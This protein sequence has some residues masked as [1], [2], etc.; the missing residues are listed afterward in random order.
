MPGAPLPA[1]APYSATEPSAHDLVNIGR[2]AFEVFSNSP[3]TSTVPASL[4]RKMSQPLS[5]GV[6]SALGLA[7]GSAGPPSRGKSSAH[8]SRLP[9]PSHAST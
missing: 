7:P 2:S 5:F 1:S 9:D 3:R 4:V 6:F 8:P